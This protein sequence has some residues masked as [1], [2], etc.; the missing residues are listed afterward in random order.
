MLFRLFPSVPVFL[1][2][3]SFGFAAE[4]ERDIRLL[5]VP[6]NGK[7][8][9][10]A[11]LRPYDLRADL[12]GHSL[13]IL[14][15]SGRE[16]AAQTPVVVVLDFAN[17]SQGNWPCL[18]AEI[19]PLADQARLGRLRVLLTSPGDVDAFQ[20]VDL[21]P[22]HP[23]HL[24]NADAVAGFTRSCKERRQGVFRATSLRSGW[25][26]SGPLL[27]EIASQLDPQTGPHR[28]IWIGED[29]RWINAFV[30]PDN[31]QQS[32]T[33]VWPRFDVAVQ[34]MGLIG[35]A[36]IAV[37]PIILPRVPHQAG[38]APDVYPVNRRAGG[39]LAHFTGGFHYDS[40]ARLGSALSRVLD[41][42]AN[43]YVL[44]L[45]S[46]VAGAK[47]FNGL[48]HTLN[49]VDR[50]GRIAFHRP[51]VIPA[52]RLVIPDGLDHSSNRLIFPTSNLRLTC[53]L[54]QAAKDILATG[55]RYCFRPRLLSI[56]SVTCEPWWNTPQ[57]RDDRF[58]VGCVD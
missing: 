14:E 50:G 12:A 27:N 11:K 34:S 10:L 15:V 22:R 35:N 9:R 1:T 30:L 4:Q 5:V 3:A 29:F 23:L 41:E 56:R 13:P 33:Y 39:A 31:N 32:E 16:A 52:E 37:F 40:G 49:L 43:G 19:A 18:A 48:P 28:L 7:Q 25:F 57:A 20:A 53:G 2:L 51:V 17:T 47:W 58:D 6:A 45:R 42:S 38:A 24:F 54:H 44:R 21:G 46:Q 8:S 36:G 26:A 55:F